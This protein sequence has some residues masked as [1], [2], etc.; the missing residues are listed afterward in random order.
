MGC[1]E[2]IEQLNGYLDGDAAVITRL[3]IETHVRRCPGC[4]HL[5]ETCKQTIRVYRLQPAAELP[6][7]L[8][9][10]VMDRVREDGRAGGRPPF[11]SPLN[12]N[13]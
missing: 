7:A 6:A 8:H 10:R 1:Q 5:V 9:R 2:I 12:P 3:E 4:W 13:S 11:G